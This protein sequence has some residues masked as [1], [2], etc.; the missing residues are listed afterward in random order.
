MTKLRW[1][2]LIIACVISTGSIFFYDYWSKTQPVKVY[3]EI[4]PD[5]SD[6]I[7]IPPKNKEIISFI[8]KSGRDIAPD[9][10][11]VVC[12]EFVIKVIEHFNQLTN[13]ERK[14][15]RIITNDDLTKLLAQDA[16]IMKGVQTALLLNKKG[17]EISVH[18]DVSPG[19]FVQ[20]WNIYGNESYGHC[21]IV[22]SIE[23]GESITLYSSHPIT[24]GYG[25]QKFAWPSKVYFARL[26]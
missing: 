19:D 26:K 9:Y 18:I 20:F 24:Q 5:I 15:V 10:S 4:T 23:P 25:I 1:A 22:A 8:E 6:S 11:S 13:E 7:P 14:A 16:A 12:T 21:G 17:I 2:I 3:T